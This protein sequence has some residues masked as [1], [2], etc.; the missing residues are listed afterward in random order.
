MT[1]ISDNNDGGPNYA[2][3]AIIAALIFYAAVQVVAAQR[4]GWAIEYPLDDVYIH[5]AMASEIARGGY[6]VNSGEIASA[7]SSALYPMLLTPFPESGFQRFLPMFWN[8]VGLILTAWIWGRA[9]IYAN[10]TGVAAWVLAIL[11]PLLVGAVSTAYV[12]MEHTLHAAATLAIIFGSIRVMVEDK[13]NWMLFAGLLV[14]PL[15]RFEGLALCSVALVLL[16]VRGR[17]MAAGLGALVTFVPIGLFVYYLTSI[18]LDPLPNSVQAKLVSNEDADMSR[19]NRTIGTGQINL[20]KYGGL[21][22]AFLSLAN[23]FVAAIG[24]SGQPRTPSYLG[25]VIGALAV[26][27]LT[28][29]SFDVEGREGLASPLF[30]GVFVG[31]ALLIFQNLRGLREGTGDP[32]W[33]W[34]AMGLAAGG[35]GHIF[36]AQTGWMERYEHYLIAG[37]SLGLLTLAGQSLEARRFMISL[38]VLVIVASGARYAYQ[39]AFQYHWSSRGIY[40][41]HYQMQRFAKEFLN[42]NVAVNDLGWIAWGNPNYV[43]DLYGLANHEA[44]ETRIFNPVPGWAGPL[45]EAG[46]VSVV[47]IY[48]DFIED[49]ISDDWIHLGMLLQKGARG[50]LGGAE[51]DFYAANQEEVPFAEDALREW[52]KTLLPDTCF[53]RAGDAP[54]W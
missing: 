51:V 12:G 6:G 43:L 11:G 47:M 2:R 7:A 41:Q 38:S 21:A 45:V 19:L 39:T 32:R 48:K 33:L 53:Y 26:A 54:C 25:F 31:L 40:L 46:D 44:R 29:V 22:I 15:F 20:V 3:V 10:L 35:I 23:L 9:I 1:Y 8:I 37:L 36:L 42:R 16:A 30:S 18:G 14:S 34:L 50:Y 52:Q 27:G 49:G 5:L 13:L 4:I 28:Y 17:P 24:S